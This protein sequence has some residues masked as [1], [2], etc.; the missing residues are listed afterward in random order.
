MVCLPVGCFPWLPGFYRI[1]LLNVSGAKA[2]NARERP[3]SITKADSF[4]DPLS[5]ESDS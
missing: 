3:E 4:W 2:I 5:D 1:I